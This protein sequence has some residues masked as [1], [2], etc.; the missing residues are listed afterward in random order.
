M[1]VRVVCPLEA[2]KEVLNAGDVC[3]F[4]EE[5]AERAL[6]DA[7]FVL[8]DAFY[9]AVCPTTAQVEPWPHLAF[10][11]RNSLMPKA[12]VGRWEQQDHE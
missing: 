11:G 5:E 2:D 6:A 12:H 1:P 8:A 4:G 9:G 3:T 7:T 10:S